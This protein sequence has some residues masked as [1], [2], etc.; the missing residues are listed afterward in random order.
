MV[1]SHTEM[2]PG[3]DTDLDKDQRSS[4]QQLQRRVLCAIGPGDIVTMYRELLDG[5]ESSTHLHKDFSKLV[6][7]W[8][9]ETGTKAHLVSWHPSSEVLRDGPYIL[10]NRP[11]LSLFS[12]RGGLK[13]HI[14]EFMYGVDIVSLAVRERVNVVIA[15]TGTAHWIVFSLLPVFGIPVI[16]VMHNTL[17][18]A[19]FPPKRFAHRLM[20]SLDGFFFRHSA[21]ATICVSPECERQVRKVAGSLKGPIYQ[22]RAQYRSGVLDRVNPI[23]PHGLRPFRV[24]FVGR[25]EESKGVFMIPSIAEQ[26]E[27]EFPG[28]FAW[29]IVG[30]G[31]ALEPLRKQIADRKLSHVE[32]TGRIS[33]AQLIEALGWAHAMVAPTTSGFCEGLAMT[34]AEGVLAGRPVVLSSVVPA[35][36]VL[37]D[38]AIVAQAENIDSFVDAFRRL[39]LEPDYYEHCRRATVEARQQFYHEPAGLGAVLGRAISALMQ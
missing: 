12:G 3:T 24:V 18:A 6:L 37:G 4:G 35:W 36:E 17:W 20:S 27:K 21:A 16:A 13:Y 1:V 30:G 9:N 28:Q 19:G 23:P 33:N 38:A 7:D 26:L 25:V 14:R 34:A 15:D 11:K 2:N 10:E 32:T 31:G 8:C 22:C 39:L 5:I 29:K